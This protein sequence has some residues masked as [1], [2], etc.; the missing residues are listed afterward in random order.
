MGIWIFLLFGQIEKWICSLQIYRGITLLYW[1]CMERLVNFFHTKEFIYSTE[2][3]ETYLT[4]AYA[5]VFI[6]SQNQSLSEHKVRTGTQ[7]AICFYRSTHQGI[8]GNKMSSSKVCFYVAQVL[9]SVVWFTVFRSYEKNWEEM[10][11][12]Y[13]SQWHE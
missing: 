13:I 9:F 11:V 1:T 12:K 7:S 5:C 10:K 8:F 6:S 3:D 2:G 4:F